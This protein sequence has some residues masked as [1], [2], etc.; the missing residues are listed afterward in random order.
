MS[1]RVG[2][3]AYNVHKRFGDESARWQ[4]AMKL[5]STNGRQAVSSEIRMAQKT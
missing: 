4:V 2:E 3:K 5:T 1:D